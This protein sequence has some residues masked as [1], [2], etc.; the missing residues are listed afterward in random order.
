MYKVRTAK[1]EFS[2][3]CGH[4]ITPGHRFVVVEPRPQFHC[5]KCGKDEITK[6]YRGQIAD[7]SGTDKAEAKAEATEERH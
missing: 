7:L 6:A 1:S 4:K 2:G 5:E 3:T